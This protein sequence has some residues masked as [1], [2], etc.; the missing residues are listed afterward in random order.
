MSRNLKDNQIKVIANSGG[1]V[2]IN[3]WLEFVD[4]ENPSLN[5]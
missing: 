2:S 5:N 3:S 1:I 4:K